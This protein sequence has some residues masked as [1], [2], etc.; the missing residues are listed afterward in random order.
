MSGQSEQWIKGSTAQG[1]YPEKDFD[2]VITAMYPTVV[3]EKNTLALRIDFEDDTQL[4]IFGIDKIKDGKVP[5][6]MSIGKFLDS[7]T[8]LGIEY[9]WGYS[10][11]ELIG[12]RT[13]PDLIG[14]HAW[15]KMTEQ[16]SVGN[17]QRVFREWTMTKY[18]KPKSKFAKKESATDK[19]SSKSSNTLER[20]KECLAEMLTEP[21]NEAKIIITLKTLVSDEKERKGLAD[22]RKQALETLVRE[23][24]LELEGGKYSI[25]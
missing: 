24:F 14:C 4:A 3:G 15:M 6:F 9:E 5:A 2:G 21:M 10:D 13:Q 22:T 18:E 12:F 17:E 19:P 8:A 23:K 16:I 25:A 1:K 11:D 7:L 20:W